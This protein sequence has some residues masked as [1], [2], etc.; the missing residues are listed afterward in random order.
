[1]YKQRKELQNLRMGDKTFKVII[2]NIEKRNKINHFISKFRVNLY[3]SSI[4][5]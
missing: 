2:K 5:L 3:V 4:I 1:M